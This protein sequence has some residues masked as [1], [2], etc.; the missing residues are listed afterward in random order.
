MKAFV[1]KFLNWFKKSFDA[2]ASDVSSRRLTAFWFVVL[3]T[4][5]VNVVILIVLLIVTKTVDINRDKLDFIKSML[6]DT[7]YISCGMILLLSGI[8]TVQQ[9]IDF[10]TMSKTSI[11]EKK[12]EAKAATEDKKVEAQINE[13]K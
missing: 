2:T 11:E 1:S 3:Q 13:S 10:K 8:V 4:S 7:Q 6:T 5:I 12:V 9:I